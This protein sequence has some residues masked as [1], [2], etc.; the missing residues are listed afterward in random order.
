VNPFAA[1]EAARLT[2]LWNGTIPKCARFVEIG[3]THTT[4]LHPTKGWRRVSN[5]R[6]GL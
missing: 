5:K 6:L 4:F 2:R 3:E 1:L